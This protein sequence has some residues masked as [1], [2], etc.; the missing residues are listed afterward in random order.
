[1]LDIYLQFRKM[2]REGHLPYGRVLEPEQH[3][4]NAEMVRLL[5][6]VLIVGLQ[7]EI[8]PSG[9]H[10]KLPELHNGNLVSRYLRRRGKRAMI[11]ATLR[12]EDG[13][14]LR[15]TLKNTDNNGEQFICKELRDMIRGIMM[16][17]VEI[18]GEEGVWQISR[19]D[20]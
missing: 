15:W 19:V 17:G 5:A 12:T 11:R 10:F 1:M 9:I 13:E 3:Y 14:K 4:E 6:F 18:L 20:V 2:Q 8:T 16:R 7:I